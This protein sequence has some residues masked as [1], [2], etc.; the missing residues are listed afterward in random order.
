MCSE[1]LQSIIEIDLY[2]FKSSF[3]GYQIPKGWTIMVG[4]R[5][6]HETA[7]CFDHL[8]AFDPSRWEHHQSDDTRQSFLPFG[9]GPRVCVGKEFAKL[10]L[11]LFL[12]ELCRSCSWRMSRTHCQVKKFPVPHPVDNLPLQFTSCDA[13]RRRAKTI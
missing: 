11:K 9:S 4:I 7:A 2:F 10:F 1:N 6:L 3:Q 13:F 12:V 8:D 5:D